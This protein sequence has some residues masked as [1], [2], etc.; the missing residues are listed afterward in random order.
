MRVTAGLWISYPASTETGV[1]KSSTKWTIFSKR[2]RLTGNFAGGS[3]SC[4]G[5]VPAHCLPRVASH[6]PR[7]QLHE[8]LRP[9]SSLKGIFW[10]DMMRLLSK[11]WHRPGKISTSR[12]AHFYHFWYG[13]LWCCQPEPPKTRRAGHSTT[14]T[15]STPGSTMSLLQQPSGFSFSLLCA[16][17]AP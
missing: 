2:S 5:G 11:V 4:G 14:A 15:S 13:V 10:S 12:S 6:C 7:Q 17:N 16:I 1:G 3:E 8:S 9:Q